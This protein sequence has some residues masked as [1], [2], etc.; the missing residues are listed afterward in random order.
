MRVKKERGER[1]DIMLK[2]M[3]CESSL[4]Y[5]ETGSSTSILHTKR[6]QTF[7]GVIK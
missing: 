3:A 7:V 1:I 6:S 5:L 4:T 2:L